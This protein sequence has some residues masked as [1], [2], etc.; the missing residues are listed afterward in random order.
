VAVMLFSRMALAKI[1]DLNPE[2]VEIMVPLLETVGVDPKKYHN[3]DRDLTLYFR[4]KPG[5]EG[6]PCPRWQ[7]MAGVFLKESP[8][9][10]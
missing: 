1:L 4:G 2:V 3:N 8:A 7:P 10:A 6:Q 9:Q 5:K